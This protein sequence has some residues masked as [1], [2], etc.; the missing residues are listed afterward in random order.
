M[1]NSNWHDRGFSLIESMVALVV[2]SFGLLGVAAMQGVAIQ[3]NVFAKDVTVATNA[4]QEI[5]ERIRLHA[6]DRIRLSAYDGM[7]T[8]VTMTRPSSNPARS[9]Y[10]AWQQQLGALRLS[11]GSGIVAVQFDQPAIGMSTVTATVRWQNSVRPNSQ[12]VT[13][14]ILEL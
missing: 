7:D 11:S 9:D 14:T 8:A 6:T 13:S 4:T 3:G 10:D 5:L 1:Q 2:L 12:L